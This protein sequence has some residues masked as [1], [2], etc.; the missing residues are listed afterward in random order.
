LI[1]F[2]PQVVH[3]SSASCLSARPD[4]SNGMVHKSVSDLYVTYQQ[5]MGSG[6][7]DITLVRYAQ[8]DGRRVPVEFI[9]SPHDNNPIKLKFPSFSHLLQYD[10]SF[11][12]L[13]GST[14]GTCD[15]TYFWLSIGFLLGACCCSILICLVYWAYKKS[16]KRR[17]ERNLISSGSK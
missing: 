11:G 4:N 16:K 17:L 6:R 12:L 5:D 7:K 15:N 2:T 3:N 9:T 13:L 1:C 8:A 14:S 10:P